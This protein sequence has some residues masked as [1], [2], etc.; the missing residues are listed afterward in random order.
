MAF[1]SSGRNKTLEN[2]KSTRDADPQG[3]FNNLRNKS[4]DFDGDRFRDGRN[5][6]PLR[7]R[8]DAGDQD[9]EGWSTV[10]PRKSFGA[11]GAER[12]HGRMGGN[13]RDEK[14]AP[15]ER[16]DR[17]ARPF[18]GFMS[19]REGDEEGRPRNHALTKGKQDPWQRSENS[20]GRV[21]EKRERID[22]A[23]SW[24]DRNPDNE[25][26]ADDPHAGRSHDSRRWGR[27][28]QPQRFE[29]E[30]EWLDEPAEPKSETRTAQDFQKWME[31]MKK[32]K[33]GGAGV[34]KTTTLPVPET[35]AQ[36]VKPPLRSPGV[37][38]GPDKFFLAFGSTPTGEASTRGEVKESA[39]PKAAA[40]KSSRFTSFFQSQD[41]GRGESAA[42]SP[43]AAL[44]PPP[45][46]PP[47]NGLGMLGLLA[48][49]AAPGS[50]AQPPDEE[51]Q[52][53]QQLLAK[54]QK[55]SVSQ[56]PPGPSPYP[57]PSVNNT[58]DA[59]YRTGPSPFQQMLGGDRQD[60][61][62]SRPPPVTHQSHEIHAPRPQP[63]AARP[64][65][66]LQDLVG[67]HH[68][69]SSQGS[70]RGESNPRNNSN[71]EFLMNLMRAGPDSQR[72]DSAMMRA[73]QQA[74]K[75]MMPQPNEREGD[76]PQDGRNSQ[77]QQMRPPPPPGF[78]AD[79]SFRGG[80]AEFRQNQP[81][82][83]LQRPPP[84]PGLDQMPPGWMGSGQMPP[85]PPQQQQQVQP[86]PQSQQRGPMLPPPGLA[87]GPGRSGPMPPHMF[88]P[89]MPP[90]PPPEA[91]GNMP[92]RNMGPP[93][94]GF[95]NGPP[96]G[97]MPP[98]MAGFNGPPGPEAPFAGSPFEGRNM[99]PSTGGR[100]A[101][102]GRG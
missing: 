62:M 94:P 92:P 21:P 20:E 52:A 102:F 74:Q 28:Q 66:L 96:H 61:P 85:P 25:A 19:H 63:Q 75:Q 40:G 90:M 67:H 16:D 65:Q 3:R 46:Q 23:K 91:M 84:P 58:G 69:V 45:P 59:G 80:E 5:V 7:R 95:F 33:D 37:E 49:P 83:I 89:N 99:P 29:R 81:T 72:S 48:S 38:T 101:S 6:N 30:P 4:G 78:P 98:G 71:T 36:S 13:F 42:A 56:T 14:R 82:Q 93:P 12:F 26:A 10:K 76:F 22:R 70:A 31:E 34:T 60:G 32:S 79:D 1:A 73:A 11:E 39:K 87:G 50:G 8:G 15:R 86:Q 17:S 44:P 43:A 41:G 55:Q 47:T 2:D 57:P 54:L 18:D 64:E 9:G 27:D 53:F 35:T 24:R 51:R 97:F 88:P 77:R 100:G 68:R